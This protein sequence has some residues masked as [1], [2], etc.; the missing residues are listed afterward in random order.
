MYKV[1]DKNIAIFSSKIGSD[2]NHKYILLDD[3]VYEQFVQEPNLKINPNE[4]PALA[5]DESDAQ[6]V[7]HLNFDDF[8]TT[9]QG[10]Y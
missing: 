5:T 7:S 10:H 2:Y 8:I 4:Q 3:D 1:D 6:D 9:V